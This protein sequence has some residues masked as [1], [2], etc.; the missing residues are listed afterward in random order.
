MQNN[1]FVNTYKGDDDLIHVVDVKTDVHWNHR[2]MPNNNGYNLIAYTNM[3]QEVSKKINLVDDQVGFNS[4][5]N[6]WKRVS[7]C[8]TSH[9]PSSIRT[10]VNSDSFMIFIFT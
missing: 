6:Q 10:T 5:R 9:F 3:Q 8:Q 4:T 1:Y 7:S 2:K